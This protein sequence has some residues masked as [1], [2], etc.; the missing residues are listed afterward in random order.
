MLIDAVFI[1]NI[2]FLDLGER[3]REE[4]KRIKDYHLEC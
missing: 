4:R 1:Y 2:G 3:E